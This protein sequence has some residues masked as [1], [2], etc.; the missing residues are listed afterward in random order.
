MPELLTLPRR[1]LLAKLIVIGLLQAA[2]L[3]A[4]AL[5]VRAA[6][7]EGGQVGLAALPVV[8]AA[9]L[10]A[11]A[12]LGVMKWREHVTAEQLGQDYIV[13]ARL[14]AFRHLTAMS[15]HAQSQFRG[16]SLQ[17]R[18][19]NDLSALRQWVALGLA[20]MVV[21][22]IVLVVALAALAFLSPVLAGVMLGVVA[23]AVL[24]ALA[25]GRSFD[26]RIREARKR[27][28]RV[29]A[30]IGEKINNMAVVQTFA[31][32]APERRRVRRQANRL[33]S[34]MVERA[35]VT[36]LFRGFMVFMVSLGLVSVIAVGSAGGTQADT[37]LALT[38]FSLISPSLFQLGRVYEYYKSARIAHAKLSALFKRGPLIQPAPSPRSMPQRLKQLRIE[39]A[40]VE[41]I[42]QNISLQIS[43]GDRVILKGRNGAGKSTLMRLMLRLIEPDKGSIT[44]NGKPIEDL[45]TGQ[46]RR[47]V[48]VISPHLPLL[49][50]SVRSNIAYGSTK[51]DRAQVDRAAKL[52][53]MDFTNPKSPFFADR[54]VS[55]GGSNLSAGEKMRII[56]A[57][58]LVGNPQ[59]LLLDE[60]DSHL[61]AETLALLADIL[62]DFPGAWLLAT[63]SDFAND[64]A[65]QHWRLTRR[66]LHIKKEAM[67]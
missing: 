11:T 20:R 32:I 2:S 52:C 55:E 7:A 37:L 67:L 53:A 46:L 5:L 41:G 62:R 66:N 24:G 13:E 54:D 14:L 35:S 22:G 50:G 33:R 3:V 9:L 4:L 6:V 19:V 57:R 1:K 40:S 65:D 51:A 49:K 45:R 8:V 27:R 15:V 61:D 64:L 23:G 43:A 60:P 48:S 29:A 38:L 59:L 34:A 39:R 47:C 21:A 63:H 17:L 56:I 44:L 16:G 25:I 18:F 36:G 30:N 10:A 28:G 12:V 42:L 26:S 58:A 31:N